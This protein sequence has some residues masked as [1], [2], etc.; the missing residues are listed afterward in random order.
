MLAACLQGCG[1]FLDQKPNQSFVLP[2]SL[3]DFQALL[4]N[5]AQV[6]NYSPGGTVFA[7]DE[8]KIT[9]QG[10][11][12]M[13]IVGREFYSWDPEALTGTESIGDWTVPYQQVFVANVVLDG[14]EEISVAERTQQW[15]MVAAQARFSR[16][17]AMYNLLQLFADP[18]AKANAESA[19]GLP[20]P[21][22]SNINLRPGRENLKA[23]YDKVLADLF[24]SL[25]HLPMEITYLTRP[26]KPAACLMLAKTYLILSEY[27]LAEE[28][29]RMS[30]DFKGD[31]LDYNTLNPGAARP[32]PP[33]NKEQIYYAGQNSIGQFSAQ[34]H[35]DERFLGS[36]HVND[37]RRQVF[38]VR[39]PANGLVNFKGSYSGNYDDFGGLAVDETV[40][41]L[42]EA[43]IRNG[44]RGE[45]TDLVNGFLRYRYAGGEIVPLDFV[46][47]LDPLGILFE[48]KHKQLVFR[49]VRWTDLRRQVA[50]GRLTTP[51]TKSVG[52][53][54]AT[55]A[56]G[57]K[58][59]TYLIP[60]EEI[61]RNGIPQNP[62]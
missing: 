9:P 4:D 55:L 25:E 48:E 18:Y 33:F 19:L 34:I 5:T 47:A 43:L 59:W 49:G 57:D 32:I 29:A 31:L 28:Y 26:S 13:F 41:V 2:K 3:G 58:K 6:F 35:F 23:T 24:A 37:L 45:A 10:F 12:S 27:A 15:H 38:F 8:L 62:R 22:S 21:L 11:A 50:E 16:A 54:T 40:F 51:L 20:Y 46:N 36:Y 53:G 1:E 44:K 7:S 17:Y 30:L 56:P 14:L 39:N 42:A 61:S 52:D 60:F